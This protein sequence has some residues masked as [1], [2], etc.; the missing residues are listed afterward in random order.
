MDMPR[1]ASLSSAFAESEARVASS[2]V[3]AKPGRR[4]FTLSYKRKIVALATGLPG[5]EIGALLRREALYSSHLTN[6]R[7]EIAHIDAKTPEPKRGR[8]P[9]PARAEK[10][11]I[12]KLE[13]ELARTQ[14]RLTQAEAIIDAQKK[15]CALLGLPISEESP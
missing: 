15:L 2:E 7:K 3:S 12:D 13:R 4:R 14:R 11:V 10:L 8:K 6:W 9:E 1:S 5:G